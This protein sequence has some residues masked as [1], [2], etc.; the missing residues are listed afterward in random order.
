M[1]LDEDNNCAFLR[2]WELPKHVLCHFNEFSAILVN[3][4]LLIWVT[5]LTKPCSWT[6]SLSFF[7][8]WVLNKCLPGTIWGSWNMII[9]P[10]VSSSSTRSARK[11]WIFRGVNGLRCYLLIVFTSIPYLTYF[12]III[13]THILTYNCGYFRI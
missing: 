12:I 3:N 4:A 9:K 6:Y 10:Y 13:C 7:F 11:Y 5:V 2:H 8:F 1:L